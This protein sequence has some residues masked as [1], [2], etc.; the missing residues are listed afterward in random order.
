MSNSEEKIIRPFLFVLIVV[1]GESGHFRPSYSREARLIQFFVTEPTKR[2]LLHITSCIA[3]C[4]E[5]ES[6]NVP[7]I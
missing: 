4:S 1:A 2:F 3:E 5:T 7:K 6:L